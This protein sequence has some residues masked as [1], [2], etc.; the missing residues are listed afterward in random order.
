MRASDLTEPIP[1]VTRDTRAVDAA[2]LMAE[3]R[4]TGLIVADDGVPVAV[5]PGSQVLRLVVPLY[6]REDPSL[7]HVF[8]EEGASELCARLND[9]TVGVL[10]D[11]EDITTLEM[12]SVLPE[13]TLIEIAMA[14]VGSHSPLIVVRDKEK[15]YHG[16][17][18]FSRAMAAIV[19]AAGGETE[20]IRQRL[21]RDILPP[22]HPVADRPHDVEGT[23]GTER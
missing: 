5:I 9:S 11:D 14:M 15:R 18:T 4:L 8:D 2:R 3:Y 7:A 17:I 16:A 1:T 6:V 22:D 20:R 13:D 10:L 19:A 21:S 12:P 23:S